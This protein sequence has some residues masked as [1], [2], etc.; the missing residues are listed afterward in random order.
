ML[1]FDPEMQQQACTTVFTGRPHPN[2]GRLL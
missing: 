1:S 2:F